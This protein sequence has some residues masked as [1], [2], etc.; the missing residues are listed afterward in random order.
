MATTT[1][2]G[3][4]G[5]EP[6]E[7]R[8]YKKAVQGLGNNIGRAEG[9]RKGLAGNPA[10]LSHLTTRE[11]NA[12][13][14][15]G[16]VTNWGDKRAVEAAGLARGTGARARG[17]ANGALAG[18]ARTGAQMDADV[19]GRFED[20]YTDQVVDTTLAGIRRD[21]DRQ[22]VMRGGSEAAF[23]GLDSTRAAVAGALADE[24]TARTMAQTE[25]SLRSDAFSASRQMGMAEQKM[26]ADMG[27]AE[28]ELGM[29][30]EKMGLSEA[31]LLDQLASGRLS[32]EQLNAQMQLGLGT[33]NREIADANREA[34]R[35]AEAE[36]SDWYG[37]TVS[38]ARGQF[39]TPATFSRAD[40]DSPSTLNQIAGLAAQGA[41]AWY[42]ANDGKWF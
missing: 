15:V 40:Q 31:D 12:V 35:M 2:S 22:A 21:A 24:S 38:G 23:G 18:V 28:G 14:D 8:T 19:Y 30:A 7:Q 10:S 34:R 17:V 42:Q 33:A 1:Q 5:M 13:N 4:Q 32:R 11:K 9:I 26:L 41:G 25:S 3:Y 27:I 6:F 29:V 16:A 39:A 37:S 20:P 36:A